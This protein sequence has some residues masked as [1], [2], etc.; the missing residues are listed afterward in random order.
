MGM[1]TPFALRPATPADV[2]TIVALIR[3][4]ADYE[5]LAHA[6]QITPA[7]LHRAL[8]GDPVYARVVLGCVGDTVVGFAL[9]FSTFSTFLGQPGLYLEDLYVQPAYRGQG[10]GKQLLNH[11]ATQARQQGFGRVE[12]SVLNWNQPAIEFYRRMGAVP[13]DEWTVYRLTG[14]ALYPP[15]VAGQDSSG[16]I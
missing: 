7:Q 15:S 5:K 2:E 6:V 10:L 4:L 9:F 13:M 14:D 3:E 11:L 8:F 16:I 1:T 12:W